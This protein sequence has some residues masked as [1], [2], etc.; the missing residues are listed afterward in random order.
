MGDDAMCEK[1][2]T[3]ELAGNWTRPVDPR[4]VR[5]LSVL[6]PGRV[7]LAALAEWS[8]LIAVIAASWSLWP[9]SWWISIPAYLLSVIAIGAR[10][11]ALG[12]L[13]HDG[14]H[15]RLFPH[16]FWNE[17][18]SQLFLSWPLLMD[19]RSYRRLHFD[20]HQHLNS[21]H[22]PDWVTRAGADWEFPKSKGELVRLFLN[23]L[24]LLKSLFML[25]YLFRYVDHGNKER[26]GW[27]VARLGF[28]V[29][30]I[31]GLTYF[32]LW[33]VFLLYWIVPMLTSLKAIHRMRIIAEHYAL[34]YDGPYRQMR[35]TIPRVWERFLIAP[36]GI[37]YHI[38]HHLFPSVPHYALP[39][40]HE[41]LMQN[42]EFAE[43]AH[44]TRGY[45][46]VLE[47]CLAHQASPA[48]TVSSSPVSICRADEV[49]A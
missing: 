49:L 1:P 30:L 48:R 20:H 37:N 40:L 4:V 12:V 18:F 21:D 42:A 16:R 8:F 27:D 11:H 44:V 24:L 36:R 13:M 34:E 9:V 19:V 43:Q 33:P 3:D 39:E 25:R 41:T 47:E 5:D 35:T 23:D 28:T 31:L 29:G 14:A 32:Q 7:I 10:Q 22:D 38:E 26:S 6:R 45:A 17:L 46:R 15:F 2:Q